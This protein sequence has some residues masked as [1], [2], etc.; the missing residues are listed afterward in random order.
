VKLF[1]KI[2]II[3]TGLI[4][5]SIALA[6][7]KKGLADEV[8]GVSRHQK[9]L[10][11]AKKKGAIDR[12][13]QSLDIIKG[14]DLVIL[15]TPINTILNLAPAVSKLVGKDCLVTDVGSTKARIS[16][17]LGKIFP[18]FVGA[19]P[20]AGSE[21]R[22]IA[23]AHPDLFKGSI[24]LLTPAKNTDKAALKKIKSFWNK[25]G[26]ETR[27]LSPDAHDKILCFTSHLPHIVAF[28]LIGIVPAQYLKFS[29]AG[30][31]DTT[32]IAASD[33]EL[34]AEIFL[35]N[36]KNALGAIDLFLQQ[37]LRIKGAIKRKDKKQLNL[38]LTKARKKRVSLD[39]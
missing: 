24:C 13:S 6:I 1:N 15:A 4:G 16:A 2:A 39:L 7:K 17:S 35:S 32:R 31:K 10:L 19:H 23:N 34:W 11:L 30:L 21:K 33:S 29:S 12:G 22:S 18:A 8:V 36:Q 27:L 26:A 14:A 28:S 25:I 20:L 38:I 3:G 5:G 9:S 37:L